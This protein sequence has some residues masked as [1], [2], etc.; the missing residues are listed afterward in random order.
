M[1]GIEKIEGKGGVVRE[2]GNERESR[3]RKE[4]SK[5]SFCMRYRLHYVCCVTFN[6]FLEL[7]LFYFAAA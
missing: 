2:E 4:D 3:E 5:I 1:R 6:S 7:I